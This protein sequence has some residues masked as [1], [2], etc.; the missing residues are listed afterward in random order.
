MAESNGHIINLDRLPLGRHDYDF[1]LTGE[2]FSQQEKS[3]LTGGEVSVHVALNLRSEDFD[4]VVSV[5]GTVQVPCDRC[6]DPVDVEVEAEENMAPSLD[7]DEVLGG[8]SAAGRSLDLEWLAY[9]L[10]V[11][12]LPLVHCHP[13]GGCNPQMDALLQD[14]LCSADEEPETQD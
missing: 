8:K 2:Y 1:T 12:N 14:H 5:K 7:E 3:E 13:E 4:A 9:E 6:L 10:V 11:V